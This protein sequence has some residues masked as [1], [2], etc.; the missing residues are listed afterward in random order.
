[1]NVLADELLKQNGDPLTVDQIFAA[2]ERLYQRC[3]GGFT[4]VALING[5]GILCFRDPFGIRPLV[6]GSTS[7]LASSLKCHQLP[8]PGFYSIL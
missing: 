5:H 7:C 6:Y 4:A 8:V 1:M 2:V 3:Q